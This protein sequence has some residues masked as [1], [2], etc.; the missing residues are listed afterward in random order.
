MVAATHRWRRRAGAALAAGALFGATTACAEPVLDDEEPSEAAPADPVPDP[1]HAAVLDEVTR[2]GDSVTAARTAL[3]EA[4]AADDVASARR[5]GQAAVG[6]L[7]ADGTT[8]SEAP[9]L[10]PAETTDRETRPTELDALTATLTAARAAG[11]ELGERVTGLLRDPIAGDLGA[12]ERDAAGMVGQAR[13]VADP[14]A[15]LDALDPAVLAL[16]G[17]ALRALA[18]AY[19]TADAEELDAARA[20]AERGV[21]HLDL[22]LEA[23]DRELQPPPAAPDT[24]P[25]DATDPAAEA[26]A[27]P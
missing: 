23:I 25:E 1:T 19:L 16:Q 7:L 9:P 8:T 17:D 13:A 10:L 5:A 27:G 4:A 14:G 22:I 18:W 26:E 15:E 6:R 3:A 12:W 2:L 20:Y 11:G 21:V 24:S